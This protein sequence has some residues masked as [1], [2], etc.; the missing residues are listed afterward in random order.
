ME[1]EKFNRI[2]NVRLGD[3]A[4]WQHLKDTRKGKISKRERERKKAKPETR[5]TKREEREKTNKSSILRHVPLNQIFPDVTKEIRRGCFSCSR[6]RKKPCQTINRLI[7]TTLTN[8]ENLY[9][10]HKKI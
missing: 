9:R 1:V 2:E 10:R 3:R 6:C 7:I 4:P 8:S 5:G